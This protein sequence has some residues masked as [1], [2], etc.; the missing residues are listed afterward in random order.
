MITNIFIAPIYIVT[1]NVDAKEGAIVQTGNDQNI[2]DI[3]N[4][5]DNDGW[6]N[7]NW[8]YIIMVI[9]LIV[10]LILIIKR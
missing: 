2:S 7:A 3:N 5:I 8:P 6:I 9:I 4:N 10:I 1:N